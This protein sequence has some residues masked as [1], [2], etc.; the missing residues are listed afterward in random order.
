MLKLQASSLA[1]QLPQGLRIFTKNVTGAD[2]MWELALLAMAMVQAK[3][4]FAP[5]ITP[6]GTS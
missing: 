2:Q 5:G 6:R 4:I 3:K 1:S